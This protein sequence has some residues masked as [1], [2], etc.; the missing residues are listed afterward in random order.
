M[1]RVPET[2]FLHGITSISRRDGG[3]AAAF[4]AIDDKVRSLQG[5][6]IAL[7][8]PV[9]V[10]KAPGKP[11]ANTCLVVAEGFLKHNRQQILSQIIGHIHLLNLWRLVA[12]PM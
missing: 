7:G 3:S 1:V 4:N 5:R 9:I 10:I 8:H 6:Y 2:N 12:L 11:I